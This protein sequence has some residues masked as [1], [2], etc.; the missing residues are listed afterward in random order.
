MP[1]LLAIETSC[2][3]TGIATLSG[4]S[5]KSP[6][7]LSQSVASQVDVHALTGG[8]V[9]EAAAR[10]HISVI[11]PLIR[12]NLT[13]NSLKSSN[14]DAIAVT[15]GPGLIPALTVGVTTACALSYAW[16][17]PIVPV[18]HL[19]GHIYSALL[20]ENNSDQDIFPALA[21]LVSGGHTLL[22]LIKQ[23]LSYQIIGS[24]VD[25]AAGEAFDKVARLLG[26]PYPGGPVLSELAQKGHSDAFDFPRP[27]IHAKNYNFSFSG[28]KTAV[29]YTIRDL[30]KKGDISSQQKA[31][32]AASFQQA[33]IDVLVTKTILAA[34][35]HQVK[36]ILLAG[37]VAA[38]QPLRA[39]LAQKT[40]DIGAVFQTAPIN[41][42]GD[43]AVMIGQAGFYAFMA[44]RIATWQEIDASARLN[45]EKFTVQN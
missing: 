1:T 8:V 42:C 43:N 41:L 24:T 16:K 30:E 45:L 19:E 26:L 6:Q 18:H 11:I 28:L 9:P 32:I 2:D 22:V 7:V 14:I 40:K 5:G 10:E 36:S 37:G 3:E 44:G 35:N 13:Q 29:L 31:D 23:H 38:N 12:E 33:V 34:Q 21:L 27:M 20:S 4:V 17:K 25:D 39:V 15:V